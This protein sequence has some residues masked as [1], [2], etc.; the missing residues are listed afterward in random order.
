M[1]YKTRANVY[2]VLGRGVVGSCFGVHF[3]VR[4][5]FGGGRGGGGLSH[6]GKS[7]VVALVFGFGM[8]SCPTSVILNQ[9]IKRGLLVGISCNVSVGGTQLYLL[10]EKNSLFT[11]V[12]EPST[13]RAQLSCK[14]LS[15]SFFAM[16][17]LL[18][19]FYLSLCQVPTLDS[20]TVPSSLLANFL[21]LRPLLG[22][23]RHVS[24]SQRH[25]HKKNCS[26]MSF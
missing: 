18:K 2:M 4:I 8:D 3:F 13:Y 6:V 17:F 19:Q 21:N 16:K 5:F 23:R 11:T 7:S 9:C 26:V 24:H 20:E 10:L 25:T 22:A 12:C 15:A 1:H 14:T